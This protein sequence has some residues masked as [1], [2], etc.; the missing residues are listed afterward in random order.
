M[1][2]AMKIAAL[3]VCTAPF[4]SRLSVDRACGGEGCRGCD[5]C[6]D[7]CPDGQCGGNGG[8]GCDCGCTCCD[9]CCK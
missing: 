6:S 2:F 3:F 9:G 5:C 8:C 4:V 1:S 7:C